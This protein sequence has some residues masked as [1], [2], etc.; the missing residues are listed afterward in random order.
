MVSLSSSKRNDVIGGVHVKAPIKSEYRT[1]LSPDALAFVAY[2]SRTYTHQVKGIL[3][4]REEMQARFDSGENPCFLEE[5][6]HIRESNWSV[7]PLPRD[8]QDRRVEI[9]GPTDRKMV[10]NALNSGANIYMP[11]FEDS[12]CP[13]W[14]NMIQGQVNLYDAIRGNIILKTASKTYKLG[15]KRAVMIVRPRGWHLWEKHCIVDGEPIPGGIFDFALHFFHNAKYLLENGSGPYYY[16]PKMQDHKEAR[17]WNDVFLTAQRALGIPAGSVRATCLIETLPAAFQMD[18]ILYELREH[19]SGL[20]CGRWD[21]L[22]SAMKTL[23]ADPNR[24][25]PDRGMLT[26][27]LPFM[28]AYTQMV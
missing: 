10:I 15:S 2:L 17:L 1:I 22:F 7:A 12:N 5:T 3:L 18:E 16:L 13:T 21:Y 24:I 23:R 20:N 14:D 4:K 25:F 11:D 27:E 28:R 26:M 8:L 19:S 6:K 9:T